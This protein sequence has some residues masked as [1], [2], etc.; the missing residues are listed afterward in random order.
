MFNR[1]H[2]QQ[3]SCRCIRHVY[4]YRIK[5]TRGRLRE[6]KGEGVL[7]H[8]RSASA[9]AGVDYSSLCG[10]K[11]VR[12]LVVGGARVSSV[13]PPFQGHSDTLDSAP[14]LLL[15]LSVSDMPAACS[16][17]P[18]SPFL[19][20]HVLFAQLSHPMPSRVNRGELFWSF[21]LVAL[22]FGH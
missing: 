10:P 1:S 18:Y 6:C 5:C 2:I 11:E 15:V 22:V 20:H 9:Q 17:S 14:T 19:C 13:T 7:D 16:V 12:L 3:V 4:N 8:L 21:D